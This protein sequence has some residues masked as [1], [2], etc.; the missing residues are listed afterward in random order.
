MAEYFGVAVEDIF[1][2]M[3]KRFRKEGAGGV[4]AVFG[5]DISG[6]GGGKWQVTVKDENLKVEKIEGDLEGYSVIL[7][8]DAETFVGVTIGKVDAGEAFSSGKIKADGDIGLLTNV[9]PQI[10][11]KYTPPEKE[12]TAKD[13]IDS[14]VDRF[15]PEKAEGVDMAIGYDLTG[16]G[17]GKW[18]ALVK[19]QTCKVEEGLASDCTVTLQMDA[20][21]FVDLNL[22]LIDGTSA[23]TS[24]QVKIEGDMG[25]ASTSAKF[26]ERFRLGGAEGAEELISL[27][28]LP[29]VDQRFATGSVMGK[30]FEGLKEKKFYATKCPKCGRTQIPPREICANCRVRCTEFVELGPNGTA[31]FIDI[32]YYA[33]P[34][35]LTG[36]VR[37]TPYGGPFFMLDGATEEESFAHGLNPKDLERIKPGM[38][39]RPVWA[40]RRTGSY[41]DLLYFEIDD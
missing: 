18:T 33:S 28:C 29:S 26:F 10:F 14:M 8:T 38:R 30:W 35:P 31:T 9:L 12:A 7:D 6:E 25:A 41:T 16:D 37:E 22:G 20:K 17:G 24:G 40:E 15:R 11:T 21:V 23:F 27:K 39:I 32:V 5:Y 13:I 1:N 36:E 3:G 19:D 2:T 34:D 4:D